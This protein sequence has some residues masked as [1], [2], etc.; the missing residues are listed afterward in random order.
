MDRF[1]G[2]F[3]CDASVQGDK[4]LD[5]V[6]EIHALLA[7]VRDDRPLV[8]EELEQARGS[9]TRGYGRSFETPRQLGGALAQLAVYGLPDD[10]FDRFVPAMQSVT[11]ED[12]AVAA[13]TRLDPSH[14]TTVVV[15]DPQ[16]QDQLQ[17]LGVPVDRVD[18][19]F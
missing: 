18:V 13:Q 19:E 15:G 1:A 11:A 16:W 14:L 3:S 17:E 4:T 5:S 6:R 2:T 10:T 9:L 12:V 8:G 7:S